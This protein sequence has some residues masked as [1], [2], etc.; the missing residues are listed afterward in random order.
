M[1]KGGCKAFCRLFAE[2]KTRES[3]YDEKCK[4]KRCKY[5]E[6]YNSV[7]CLFVGGGVEFLTKEELYMAIK[8]EW[9]T[10]CKE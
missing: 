6:F 7:S 2:A 3:Y 4:L 10:T 1:A 9:E 8:K 5:Y